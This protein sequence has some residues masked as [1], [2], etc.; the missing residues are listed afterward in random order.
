M[1]SGGFLRRQL[2]YQYYNATV[3]LIVA[4][5][6]MFIIEFFAARFANPYSGQP[7]LIDYLGLTPRD[8]I[9]G[10][11]WWQVV[12]YMFVH[13][14]FMHLFFNMLTLYLFGIQLEHRM[15]SSEFLLFYFISGIGA[16]L[17]TL[18]VNWYTSP[19]TATVGAS[20]A[21]VALLLAFATFFPD[22]MLYV[23]GI[24]P[25][26]APTAV[27]VFAAIN[28]VF[29]FTGLA[30]GIAYLTHLAGV[31]VG[32]LLLRLRYGVKPIEAFIRRR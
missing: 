28:V 9:V 20:G 25:M 23:F 27:L 13:A 3:I 15:G 26:R 4:N 12:T 18:G 16:G 11:M 5:V 30:S 31:L 19:V 10:G 32:W 21:I 22:A 14:N 6:V 7:T 29:M 8:V 17:V 2:R 1:S 24:L